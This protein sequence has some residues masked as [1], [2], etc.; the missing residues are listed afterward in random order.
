MKTLK[1][2]FEQVVDYDNLYR[3]YLNARLCKRYRY[4][5]LNFSAHLEDNL[6]KLQKELIERTYTLGKYREFYI[7]EPK[8]RLIMA[9]PFK[10]RVVQWAIYQVL[11]P[12]FAQGYITDSYACIKERG[13]HKAVKRLHYWLR[14]VGKKPEKYYFL[15]LDISKYFYRIDHDVLMGILKRKIRDDDMIFLLDKIV[16]SSETN[17]GLPPG[18]SPGEVKRSDRV[19]E[20][21]MPVGNLSS[22]MFANLYLNELDQYCKRT[23]GIHFYVRYMDDVIILHQDKDQLH[24]W[25]RIIDTFLKEKLQLDLNE[26]TCIRPITLGVEFCGYKIWNTHIKLR[27]STALKMKRN[28]KKLQ[29]EYAAGEVT[30]E[31][32]KQTISSYLGILKHCDSY[33]LK[34]TIFGEYGSSEE[35]EGWFF[36]QRATTETQ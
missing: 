10:D 27:K 23:L 14:Q 19:S 33:S 34:R 25:K 15:K 1:N 7:Y 6:V 29:K 16:N 9:Q 35:Y 8:K 13:T 22:Q 11:N 26:K 30:V 21:G 36:L 12:V 31:E 2:V 28:L 20:K 18:K 17:F 24:E 5:V 4:E 32:A 3:A